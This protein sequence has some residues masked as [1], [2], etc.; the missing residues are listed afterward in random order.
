MCE[1]LYVTMYHT[2]GHKHRYTEVTN[3]PKAT[4]IRKDC[5]DQIRPMSMADETYDCVCFRCKREEEVLAAASQDEVVEEA[6]E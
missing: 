3:C 1:L 4:T 5:L 2:C 6:K